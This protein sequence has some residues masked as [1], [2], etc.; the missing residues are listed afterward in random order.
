LVDTQEIQMPSPRPENLIFGVDNDR[1][2]L[3][4]KYLVGYLMNDVHLVEFM[5]RLVLNGFHEITVIPKGGDLVLLKYVLD[6]L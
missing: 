4:K 3:L 2:H 6:G 1:I 5:D